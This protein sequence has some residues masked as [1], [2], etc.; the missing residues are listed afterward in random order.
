MAHCKVIKNLENAVKDNKPVEDYMY[1][2][3]VT[4]KKQ[5]AIQQSVKN[6]ILSEYTA[7]ICVNKE[8][9]DGKFEEIKDKGTEKVSIEPIIPEDFMMRE[10]MMD[11]IMLCSASKQSAPRMLAKSS[12]IKKKSAGS[13][14]GNMASSIAEG[15][16]SFF[17]KKV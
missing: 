14:L 16:T 12:G 8:L 5:E 10:K 11:N 2:V 9:V 15:V 6:Q 17:S 13:F 4:D 7:F 3:K 1:Y